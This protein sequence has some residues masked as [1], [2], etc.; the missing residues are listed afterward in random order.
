MVVLNEGTYNFV[1]SSISVIDTIKGV[2]QNNVFR[3]V[4]QFFLGDVA[5]DISYTSDST[6]LFVV[7]NNSGKA[8][9]ISA[10]N[11]KVK[12]AI[13]G[14]FTSPRYAIPNNENMMVTD[15]GNRELVQINPNSGSVLNRLRLTGLPNKI[16]KYNSFFWIL[17]YGGGYWDNDSVV[18]KINSDNRLTDSVVVGLNPSA[19]TESDNGLMVLCKGSYPPKAHSKAQLFLIKE[20]GSTEV[21]HQ[22]TNNEYHPDYLLYLSAQNTILTADAKQ[23]VKLDLNNNASETTIK[24]DVTTIYGLEQSTANRFWICDAKDYVRNGE[25]CESDLQGNINRRYN[26]GIIPSKMLLLY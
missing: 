15:W 13:E 22:F 19:I 23:I 3:S 7:V 26:V 2:V 6:N 20:D 17:T 4:N 10:D 16:K 24:P 9:T 14:V 11:F 5:Q 8:F 1:N 18:Y 12:T 25:I 21:I